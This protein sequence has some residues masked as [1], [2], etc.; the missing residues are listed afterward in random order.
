MKTF[1]KIMVACDLSKYSFQVVKQAGEL[2][3]KFKAK[4]IIVNVI[5]QRD[6]MAVNEAIVRLGV[7]KDQI[8]ISTKEYMEGLK[9]ERL[10]EIEKLT[11]AANCDHL[12]VEI[13]LRTGVPF[14]ELLYAAEKEGVDMVVMGTK[15]RSNVSRVLFGS[16]A[17]KMFRHCPVPLLSVRPHKT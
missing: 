1:Q 2:A 16:T 5:N 14:E 7:V 17:E 9:A 12:S 13:V 10:E 6:Y 15:G 3:E 4:L 11:K 8:A